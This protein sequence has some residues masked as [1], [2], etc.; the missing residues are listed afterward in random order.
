MYTVED[1]NKVAIKALQYGNKVVFFNMINNG[2]NDYNSFA[3]EASLRGY[4]DLL[5][6]L[7]ELGADNYMD[8]YSNAVA[9]D[10]KEMMDQLYLMDLFK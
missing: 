5:P 9:F 3:Y 2:A 7:F 8:V 10:Y 4:V 1:Y 6:C